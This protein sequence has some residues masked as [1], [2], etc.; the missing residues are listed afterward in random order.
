MSM[1]RAQDRRM[2][3]A[4]LNAEIV[5]EAAATAQQGGILDALDRTAD[6]R[7]AFHVDG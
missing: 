7:Q 5:D 2:K 3:S 6:P 1:R 4:R